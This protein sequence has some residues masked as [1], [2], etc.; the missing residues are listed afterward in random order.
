MR[1]YRTVALEDQEFIELLDKRH[2]Q[3]LMRLGGSPRAQTWE[4]P[5]VRLLKT[6]EGKK[7][8]YSDMPRYASD[9]IVL[10]KPAVDAVGPL[11]EH[12]GELLP[13]ECNQAPLWLFNCT[14]VVDALDEERSAVTRFPS[15]G[16]LMRVE[17]P[18]FRPEIIDGL[19][20]FKIPQLPFSALYVSSQVV[21]AASALELVRSEF[22]LVWEG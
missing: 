4:V 16:R 8:Q 13:L 14:R 1:I 19:N 6:A 15:T 7:L 17:T 11:I 21:E 2:I 3:T 5:A 12:D 10:R 9:V 20:A 18:V 22:Q